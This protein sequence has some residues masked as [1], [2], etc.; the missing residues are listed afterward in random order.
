M[1][2]PLEKLMLEARLKVL[3][4]INSDC[5]RRDPQRATAAARAI[6]RIH[7]GTYGYCMSCGMK[8]AER[9]TEYRP[10][11]ED[12]SRCERAVA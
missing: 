2:E 11:R 10:D 6:R 1:A 12:C 7:D 5:K 9:E 3:S 4:R 8:M